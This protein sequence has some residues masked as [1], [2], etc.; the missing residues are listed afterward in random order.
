MPLSNLGRMF[1]LYSRRIFLAMGF[2]AQT[3]DTEETLSA[4][5]TDISDPQ[6]RQNRAKL[7]RVWLEISAWLQDFTSNH[8][9]DHS[10][11]VNA[12]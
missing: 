5:R 1:T 6:G 11:V 10:I 7:L 4:P 8:R 9:R 2:D 3:M 12:F